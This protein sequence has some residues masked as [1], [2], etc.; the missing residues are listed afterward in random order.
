[1]KT[2]FWVLMIFLA[3]CITSAAWLSHFIIQRENMKLMDLQMKKMEQHILFQ[4]TEMNRLSKE[5]NFWIMETN[6][7]R[8]RG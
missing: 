7:L 5:R 3:I 6:R 2:F 1:M 4:A 8:Q